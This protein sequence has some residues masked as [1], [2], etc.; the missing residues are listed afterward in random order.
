MTDSIF[1]TPIISSKAFVFNEESVIGGVVIEHDVIVAPGASIRADEC[2]PF[3]IGKGT[4]LQDGVIF[5]GLLNRYI[6]VGEEQFSIWVG[7]HC[8]IAHRALNSWP[9]K[10]R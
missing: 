6:E 8:S 9:Y 3:Y 7:S 4:N 1:G 2:G 5:H 10:N